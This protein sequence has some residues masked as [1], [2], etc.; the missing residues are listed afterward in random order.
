[1]KRRGLEKIAVQKLPREGRAAMHFAPIVAAMLLAACQGGGGDDLDQFMRDADKTMKVKIEPLPEVTPYVPMQYNADG[2]LSDPF[3]ARKAINAPS[4]HLQP[5][6][7]RPREPLE[8]YPLENLKFVGSI[9]K[10]KLKYA[11]IKAPDGT[12]QQVKIGNYIGQN[13]GLV[14][15]IEATGI[16]LKEIVQDE[17]SGEWVERDASI[18]L[19]E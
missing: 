10:A 16:V 11:L 6:L 19:Q 12:V 9:E 8:L 13:F 14:T 17:Q 1:M 4:G 2:I 3:V 7:T 15:N 5:N 18:E